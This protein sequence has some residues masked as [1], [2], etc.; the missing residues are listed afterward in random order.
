[1]IILRRAAAVILIAPFVVLLLL[2]IIGQTLNGSLLNPAFLKEQLVSNDAYAFAMREAVPQELRANSTTLQELPL[3]ADEIVGLVQATI[4]ESFLQEQVELAV[5]AALPYIA[6]RTDEVNLTVPLKERKQVFERALAALLIRKYDA[7][8]PC[9]R[10]ADFLIAQQFPRCRV[11]DTSGNL[12][13]VLINAY[14]AL[15]ACASIA[16]LLFNPFPAC[17]FGAVSPVVQSTL[18]DQYQALP[19]CAK[20]EQLL[21]AGAFPKCKVG[22]VT[23]ERLLQLLPLAEEIDKVVPDQLSVTT[24][25]I[26]ENAPDLENVRQGLRGFRTALSVALAVL[27]ALLLAIAFLGGRS[28][29]GRLQWGAAALALGGLLP[30]ATAIG[31]RTATSKAINEL[32]LLGTGYS[33]AVEDKAF[34]IIQSSVNSIAGTIQIWA[35]VLL[36]AGLLGVVAP[37]FLWRKKPAPTIPRLPGT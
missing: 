16:D 5:D 10:L 29:R 3:T 7:L 30:L 2:Q 15:P 35:I 34:Q 13:P 25:D 6:G 32:A 27:A 17:K 19:T 26:A 9:A 23:P 18:E 22:Q 14:D 12:V 21:T 20:F 11:G 4:S 24:A 8:P 1:M 28:W 31:A 36:A 33:T 37:F